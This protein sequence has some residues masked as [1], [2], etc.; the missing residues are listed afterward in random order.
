MCAACSASAPAR[1]SSTNGVAM[2]SFSPLSTLS[3]RRTPEGTRVS[4]KM[5]APRAASVGATMAPMSAATHQPMPE[6]SPKAAAAPAPIVSGRPIA[7]SRVGS[8]ASARSSRRLTLAASVNSTRASVSSAKYRS[9][10]DL[11]LSSIRCSGWCVTATPSRTKAIGAVTFH[12]SRRA[13][14]RPQSTTHPAMTEIAWVLSSPSTPSAGRQ[15]VVGRGPAGRSQ[16]A[17]IATA[18]ASA[19]GRAGPPRRTGSRR[20]S[21][22]DRSGRFARRSAR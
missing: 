9:V 5:A 6:K 21:R 22:S 17:V 2:P 10:V 7:S 8:T 16:D 15:R 11:T 18:A 4:C 3:S 19:R 1:K 12:R 14:T 20:P 13:E